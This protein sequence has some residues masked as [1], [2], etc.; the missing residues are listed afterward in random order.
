MMAKGLG[1]GVDLSEKT[2]VS[3][4]IAKAQN[5][6]QTEELLENIEGQAIKS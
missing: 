6:S 3:E 4:S 1:D 5:S 2:R